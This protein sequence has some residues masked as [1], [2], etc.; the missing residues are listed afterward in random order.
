M[1]LSVSCVLVVYSIL[2]AWLAS[3]AEAHLKVK[4]AGLKLHE[5]PLPFRLLLPDKKWQKEEFLLLP[6]KN[7]YR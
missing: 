5:T 7:Y 1:Y 4:Q 2:C 6:N 3:L